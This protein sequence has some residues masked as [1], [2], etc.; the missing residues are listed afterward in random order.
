LKAGVSVRTSEFVFAKA[1]KE[2]ERFEAIPPAELNDIARKI[3][4]IP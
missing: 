3:Q 4:V 1:R 2:L